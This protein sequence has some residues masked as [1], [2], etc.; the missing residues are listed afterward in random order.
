MERYENLLTVR[1]PLDLRRHA[2]LVEA[3]R[4]EQTLE[5]VH[6]AR[7]VFVAKLG[8]QGELGAAVQLAAARRGPDLS[9][10]INAA[11]EPFGLRYESDDNAVA[12]GFGLHRDVGEAASGIKRIDRAR[13]VVGVK[14]S[15]LLQR[16]ESFQIHRIDS[17]SWF[18]LNL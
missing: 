1:V 7:H 17:Q 9:L 16:L 6:G 11:H 3:V 12:G 2:S 4:C 14:R 5:I 15:S 18:I 10:H 13:H 8:S